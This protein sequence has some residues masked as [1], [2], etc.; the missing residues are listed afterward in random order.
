[1]EVTP[2]RRFGWGKSIR[3]RKHAQYCRVQSKGRRIGG[4]FLLVIF[5][6]SSFLGVRFG[7]TVSKKVGKAVVRN[8]V[9]RRLRDIL[10]HHQAVLGGLDVVWIAKAD[11]ASASYASLE[12]EVVALLDRIHRSQS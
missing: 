4:K 2:G 9:K 7:L 1:M 8:K 11:A 6:P 12:R 5:A 10:R 3:L